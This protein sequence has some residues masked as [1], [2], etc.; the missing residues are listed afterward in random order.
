MGVLSGASKSSGNSLPEK[1]NVVLQAGCGALFRRVR[2]DAQVLACRENFAVGRLASGAGGTDGGGAYQAGSEAMRFLPMILVAAT[3]GLAGPAM[4]QEGAGPR[5]ITVTGAG[6]AVAVP[7]MATITIGVTERNVGAEAAADAVATQ[8]GE[9]MELLD[10]LGIEPRDRQTTGLTLRPVY[11]DRANTYDEREVVAFEAS[12]MLRTRVRDLD[13]LGDVLGQVIAQG[14]NRLEGLEFGFA[15]PVPL[16]DAAR[17]DAV[18]DAMARAELYAEAAGVTLGPVMSIREGGGGGGPVPMM[19][20]ADAMESMPV[21][22][23]ESA[24]G[25]SVTVVFGIE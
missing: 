19:R 22:A 18:Q 5:T 23:G 24:V 9:V 20:M 17:R 1:E 2:P 6:E 12:N 11:A 21:A 4:A 25:A 3:V 7:D 8:I 15:E 16:E 13:A 10:S 14:A